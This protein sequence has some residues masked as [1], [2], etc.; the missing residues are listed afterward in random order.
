MARGGGGREFWWVLLVVIVL[1]GLLSRATHTG[2]R[3]IDKYLGD[4][5][6]AG[7]VYV[8]LRL[9]GRVERVALWAAAAMAAI[10]CFQL[11]GIPAGLWRSGDPVLRVLARVLGTEFSG[12][13]L[14]AYGVGI[15]GMAGVGA[16]RNYRA[17]QA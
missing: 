9:S 7:M 6:Y 14:L 15:L 1:A 11:T 12:W 13:D 10:E 16:R 8:L 17:Y 2:F 3:L 4:A 5:L